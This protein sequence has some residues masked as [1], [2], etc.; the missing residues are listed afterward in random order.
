[1]ITWDQLNFQDGASPIIEEFIFFHDFIIL[2]LILIISFVGLLIF[3]RLFN[4]FINTFLLEG[5]LLERLWT[6]LPGV[7]LL[8][9]ALPSLC[10]LYLYEERY[11]PHF[12][13]KAVGRQWYWTYEYSRRAC[14]SF[15]IDSIIEKR[16][17][18][19]EFRSLDVDSRIILPVSVNIRVLI[20]S[21]DVLHAWTVPRIGVKADAT[22][23]RINQLNIIPQRL[24]VFFGQ[25]SEICGGNHSFIPIVIE[26]ITVENFLFW[27]NAIKN[28]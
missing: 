8:Q 3:L 22:P 10:L 9:I 26:V 23:G 7:I 15:S 13:V 24:G 12:T 21:G 2:I 4:T 17:F 6:F 28:R 18:K 20:T 1:M 27:Y 19:N 14:S 5:Q 25:C 11:N 16:N